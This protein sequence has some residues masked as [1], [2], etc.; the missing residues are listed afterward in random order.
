MWQNVAWFVGGA[1]TILVAGAAVSYWRQRRATRWIASE[2]QA[3]FRV[4]DAARLQVRQK[5]FPQHMAPD[6]RRGLDEWLAQPG[7]Q[8]LVMG[9]PITDSFMSEIGIPALIAPR[10]EAWY[11]PSSVEYESYD[12]G[13][14]AVVECPRHALWLIERDGARLALLWTYIMQH[15]GCGFVTKLKLE[16]GY[17][18]G[19]EG[20]ELAGQ[21]LHCLETSVNAGKAYRGR[22]LSM[23]GEDD[24][25]GNRSGLTVHRLAHVSREEVILPDATLTLLERNVVRFVEQRPT[26]HKFGM[27]TR[28]G[29][30][31]YGPPGVGKTHTIHY[32]IGALRGHT[33]L[34]ITSEQIKNISEYMI[35]ARLLQPCLVVIEDVDLIARH[36][37]E[38]G[39]GEQSVLNRLLNE[40][41]GLQPDAQIVFVLTTNRP[42]ALEE[43][44]SARPGRIDQAIEFPLPDARGRERL[45]QLYAY[46]A[47]MAAEVTANAVKQTEG[48]SGSFIK[49]LMRRAIQFN[50]EC[51]L[52]A[53]TAEVLQND[54]DQ[55]IEEMLW[56]GGPLNR[57]LLGAGRSPVGD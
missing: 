40:M 51:R 46:G 34:L 14:D 54:V 1:M 57:A 30:L 23:E 50:L 39:V 35:L 52:G 26:L 5:T 24:Y 13:E 41:D 3:F 56:S 8:A 42:E 47:K 31:F 4:T 9:V 6:A 43:A 48:V 20:S 12:V 28:K 32:L 27:P 36:R 55:A 11:Q 38:S 18:L 19:G 2:L 29:L 7:I 17:V 25:R 37:A 15:G 53:S 10:D 45:M 16:A 33:T 22:V 21:L 44:L 49:E